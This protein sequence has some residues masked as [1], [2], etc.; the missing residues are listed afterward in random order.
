[1]VLA[2]GIHLE[3]GDVNRLATTRTTICHC[4]GANLKLGSGIADVAS[5]LEG[6]VRVAIGADGP[7]CNNRLS[8]FHELWLAATLPSLRHGPGAIDPWQVLAMA[9]RTGAEA[10]H[11]EDQIGTL[12]PGKAAD[13]VVVDLDDWS[14]LPGG[15]PAARIVFGGSAQMVRHTLVAG[16][17]LVVDH[18]LTAT[19]VRELRQR[20]EAAWHATRRRMEEST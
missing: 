1:V 7:P 3:P 14:M 2:H 5:L 9:T 12:E 19:D 13:L 16:Q 10:L 18:R 15:D 20:I 6:G 8:V 4:P 11:L 17:P